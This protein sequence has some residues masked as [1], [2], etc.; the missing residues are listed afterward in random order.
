MDCM[1]GWRGGIGRALAGRGRFEIWNEKA[2]R[3]LLDDVDWEV[4]RVEYELEV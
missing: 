4:E 2:R 1:E 3:R